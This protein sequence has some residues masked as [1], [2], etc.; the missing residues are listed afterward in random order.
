VG[1]ALSVPVFM[2]GQLQCVPE[3]IELL[4]LYL[5]IL[6]GL[7]LKLS[8]CVTLRCMENGGSAPSI[9][10]LKAILGQCSA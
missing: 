7:K 8:F 5:A 9:R 2:G 4:A 1:I 6:S 10:T 3:A